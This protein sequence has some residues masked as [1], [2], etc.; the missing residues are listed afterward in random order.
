MALVRGG[1]GD[2]VDLSAV[3]LSDSRRC[4]RLDYDKA[5]RSL[6]GDCDPD[7]VSRV[8][9]SGAHVFGLLRPRVGVAA[10]KDLPPDHALQTLVT[11]SQ[12]ASEN[13]T[14]TSRSESLKRRIAALPQ[15]LS[16]LSQARL[17]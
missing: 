16:R 4:R 3:D 11:G 15:P 17:F 1:N 5:H 6:I 10:R 12:A 9:T 2:H 13:S 14:T 7:V 8:L